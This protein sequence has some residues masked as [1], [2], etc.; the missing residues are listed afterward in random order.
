LNTDA[1]YAAGG[2]VLRRNSGDLEVLIIHRPRY[3]DWSF[4]KGKSEPG[5][6]TLQTALRE[7]QEETSTAGRALQELATIGYSTS[8]VA[9]DKLVTYFVMTPARYS[10]FE[11]NDE[12]DKV[13][14]VPLSEAAKILSY[15]NDIEILKA[16]ESLVTESSFDLYS[17]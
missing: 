1:T 3:N 4:P 6:T 7:V 8:E 10:E 14:W 12:V 5:E 2:V 13:M 16:A 15:P 9:K 17:I 11:A